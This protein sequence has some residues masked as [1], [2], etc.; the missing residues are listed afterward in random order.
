M[1]KFSKKVAVGLFTMVSWEFV[2]KPFVKNLLT[3]KKEQS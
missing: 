1:N 3:K 2:I